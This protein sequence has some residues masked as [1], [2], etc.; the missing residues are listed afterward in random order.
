MLVHSA[1]K[2]DGDLNGD[3]GDAGGPCHWLVKMRGEGGEHGL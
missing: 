3:C 2:L 1:L